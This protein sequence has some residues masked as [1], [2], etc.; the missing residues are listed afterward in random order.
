MPLEKPCLTHFCV[1]QLQEEMSNDPSCKQGLNGAHPYHPV[2]KINGILGI[3]QAGSTQRVLFEYGGHSIH[4]Q[5]SGWDPSVDEE[6]NADTWLLLPLKLNSKATS[7][8]QKCPQN[9]W[10]CLRLC[11]AMKQMKVRASPWKRSVLLRFFYSTFLIISV[12]SL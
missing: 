10:T 2:G 1:P 5:E 12:T 4:E 8:Q 7:V 11:I 3:G 9:V 6:I